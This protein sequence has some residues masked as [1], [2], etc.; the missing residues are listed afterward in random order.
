[1]IV[2]GMSYS[3]LRCC[4]MCRPYCLTQLVRYRESFLALPPLPP[5]NYPQ[6]SQLP[7]TFA[8]FPQLSRT[9]PN[10]A[11]RYNSVY[12]DAVSAVLPSFGHFSRSPNACAQFG[13][14]LGDSPSDLYAHAC[15]VERFL[16]WFTGV[17][18]FF[19]RGMQ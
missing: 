4:A 13:S 19:G 16:L 3:S 8:H 15:R 1:M 12:F 5:A 14:H 10:F 17:A 18:V 6:F 2:G 11:V 7:T 9:S